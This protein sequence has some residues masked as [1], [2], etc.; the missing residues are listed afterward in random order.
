VSYFSVSLLKGASLR[1]QKV[2]GKASGFLVVTGG[3]GAFANDVETLQLRPG[4]SLYWNA[5][6]GYHIENTG[7]L[8]LTLTLVLEDGAPLPAIHEAV[9]DY[10]AHLQEA[11]GRAVMSE[12][13]LRL[14]AMR[15]Q[16]RNQRS[17]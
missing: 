5:A 2:V 16:P 4:D 7:P 3:E 8:L 17:G 11:T 10:Y 12:G 1:Q 14:A 15:R 6:Y 9:P 13:P